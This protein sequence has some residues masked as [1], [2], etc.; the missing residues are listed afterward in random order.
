[1]D[2]VA[3]HTD[4]THRGEY[5]TLAMQASPPGGD[6]SGHPIGD[7]VQFGCGTCA[8]ST[9]LNFD[10]GPAFWLER[11]LHWIKPLLLRRGFPDYPPNII[12]G[13]VIKGLPLAPGS[14]AAV[15]CSHVLEH[16]ALSDLRTTLRNTLGYLRPGGTFRFVLP[17]L[18]WLATSYVNASDP[19]AASRFMRD[20]YLGTDEQPKGTAGLMRMVFGRSAH[21]WM[22]DFKNLFVELERAG[23]TDIRRAQIFDNPDPRFRDVEDP[24]R[25]ENCLGM[26]CRRA[27]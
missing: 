10:A 13:D 24:G 18:E 21:L 8:P 16:L 17:D 12:Y 9:W 4:Q 11:N 27:A 23:F 2:I 19:E 14:A 15:Y 22:W 6:S 7:Y 25:W 1:M 26:E 3:R 20:S 5:E